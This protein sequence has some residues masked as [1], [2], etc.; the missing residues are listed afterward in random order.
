MPPAITNTGLV[1]SGPEL[2]LF[3]DGG[4]PASPFTGSFQNG[5]QK[6]GLAGRL[7]VNPGVVAD[8]SRLVVYST[9]PLTPSG[10]STRPALLLERLTQGIQSFS[11]GSGIGGA[12]S[13]FTGTVTAFARR[14]V[15]T[16]AETAASAARLDEGQKIVQASI[17]ARYG[18][19]SGVSV[20]Q[21]L[22]QLV[23]I[24]NAYSANARIM[25]AVRDMLDVLLR[26]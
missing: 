19:A 25:S 16:Q 23:Q 10:D 20:D 17:D 18:Q 2:A 1:G 4:S 9:S 7:I 5:S 15:D 14:L 26:I 11:P 6:A 3:F 22:S 12:T 21:E 24:Q 8:P 13:P